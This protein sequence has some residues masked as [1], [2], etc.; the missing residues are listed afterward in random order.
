MASLL[1]AYLGAQSALR[2]ACVH[3]FCHR[4]VRHDDCW[5][6]Y[7]LHR[8]QWPSTRR[9]RRGW[10]R[11]AVSRSHMLHRAL[12]MLHLVIASERGT[13][14][15]N[16]QSRRAEVHACLTGLMQLLRCERTMELVWRCFPGLS[17]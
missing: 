17:P 4:M 6:P 7:T 5:R 3:T 13:T 16:P 2:L 14:F 15:K 1:V 11:V 12:R 9:P 10:R 8:W